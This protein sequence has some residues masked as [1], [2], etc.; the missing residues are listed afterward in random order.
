MENV[1]IFYVHLVYITA[2]EIFYVNL[3]CFVVVWYIFP[4]F[5]MLYQEKSGSPDLNNPLFSTVKRK[6]PTNQE[7]P[8]RLVQV[9]T[10]QTFT[11]HHLCT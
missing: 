3:V 6:L 8:L 11:E 10:T 1:G 4:H 9:C 5:G 2:I 7:E